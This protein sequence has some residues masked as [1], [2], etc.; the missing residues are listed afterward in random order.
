LL[1]EGSES[2]DK[3]LVLRPA[4]FEIVICGQGFLVNVIIPSQMLH[5][6]IQD[7]KWDNSTLWKFSI[8][9]VNSSIHLPLAQSLVDLRLKADRPWK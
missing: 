5:S 4:I 2:L 7:F 3:V 9:M 6:S 1:K 8:E